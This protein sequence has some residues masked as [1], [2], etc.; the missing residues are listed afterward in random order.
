[1]LLYI[2]GI[3]LLWL[4][5]FW[6]AALLATAGVVIL[7]AEFFYYREL[8]DPLYPR[9]TGRNVLAVVEP[10]GAGCGSGG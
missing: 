4:E 8:L 3:V 9:Q 7:A 2:T 1:M 5:V 10:A 6:L